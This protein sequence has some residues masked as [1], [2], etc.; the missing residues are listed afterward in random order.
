[1]WFVLLLLFS[2]YPGFPLKASSDQAWDKWKE[3]QKAECLGISKQWTIL[4]CQQVSGLKLWTSE[5]WRVFPQDAVFSEEQLER[6]PHKEPVSL[7]C[8]LSLSV[9]SVL[10]LLSPIC[11]TMIHSVQ[12][13][14]PRGSFTNSLLHILICFRHAGLASFPVLLSTPQPSA[15]M[16]SHTFWS[17]PLNP[18][19]LLRPSSSS[20][21]PGS[22]P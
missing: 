8:A 13:H 10:W 15:G 9:C 6:K 3:E 2:R 22:L 21:L 18:M 20:P 14:V 1:M 16:P 7:I 5:E 4:G 17:S 12:T 19:H 11:A